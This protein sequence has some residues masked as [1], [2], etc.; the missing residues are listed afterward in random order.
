MLVPISRGSMLASAIVRLFNR[1]LD[2]HLDQMQDLPVCDSAR[3]R[4]HQWSVRNLIEIAT[5]VRVD[6]RRVPGIDRAVHGFDRAKRTYASAVRVLFRLQV[7]FEDW[8]KHHHHRR[9]DNTVAYRCH[10]Y[11]ELHF[12]PVRLWV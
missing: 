8:F 7:S 11:F 2:P 4:F 10:G 3:H 12:G 6:H 1:R 5:Q 9:L